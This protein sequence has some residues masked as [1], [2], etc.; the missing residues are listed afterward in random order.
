MASA[1]GL[2]LRGLHVEHLT[3]LGFRPVD[4]RLQFVGREVRVAGV[5]ALSQSHDAS[6][7]LLKLARQVP[8]RAAAAR[9]C[10]AYTARLGGFLPLRGKRFQEPALWAAEWVRRRRSKDFTRLALMP[11]ARGS[12]VDATASLLQHQ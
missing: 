11:S 7:K 9:T 12:D 6:I 4:S 5:Q 2:V 8:M 10:S 1:R 3:A